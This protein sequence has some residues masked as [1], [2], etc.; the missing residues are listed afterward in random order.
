MEDTEENR[1]RQKHV[2]VK[3]R[4]GVRMTIPVKFLL[5]E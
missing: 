1:K 3:S 2:R 5:S 4:S